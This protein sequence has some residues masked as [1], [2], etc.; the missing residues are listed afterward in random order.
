M[1]DLRPGRYWKT[2]FVWEE[3]CPAPKASSRLGSEV[4]NGEW[5]TLAVA[6]TMASSLDDSDIYAV[7]QN[8]PNQAASELITMAP[9]YFDI[10]PGWWQ[11]AKDAEGNRVGFVLSALFKGEETWKDG[12]PEAT[13]FY[14][15]VLP[16]YRGRGYGQELLEEAVR[17]CQLANCW[18]LFC[19]TGTNNHPMVSAF[20]LA[21]FKERA[22]MQRPIAWP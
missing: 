9:E 16:A 2:P 22:P 15:G 12:R 21:G 18:R 13:I 5:L 10:P 11:V 3:G 17:T 6:Q 19:D 4:A 1:E 14:M 7:S 20:R 8:G